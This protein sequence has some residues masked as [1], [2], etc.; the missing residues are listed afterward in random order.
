MAQGKRTR[1]GVTPLPEYQA[2]KPPK[3]PPAPVVTN[4]S[5]TGTV[6]ND[7]FL[8][9]TGNDTFSGGAGLDTVDYSRAGTRITLKSQGVIDK[10]AGGSDLIAG[11]ESIIG[12]VG[13]ANLIDGY[14]AGAQTT[15][16]IIDLA[17][18]ALTINGIPYL[19]SVSFGVTNFVDVRG[20]ANGDIITGST[21]DNRFFGSAGNDVYNGGAGFD[22]LD[23][24]TLGTAV[25]LTSQGFVDKGALGTD[26]ISNVEAILGATGLNNVIDG[27]VA[28][29]ATQTTSFDVDLATARLTVS[30]IP[31]LGSVTFRVE[32]FS[33]VI[34]TR[35]ADKVLGDGRDNRLE[36]A[37]GNDTLGGGA[38]QDVLVGG[39]GADRLEGGN[40]DDVLIGGAG[41]DVLVLGAGRDVVVLLAREAESDQILDFSAR[42]DDIQLSSAGFGLAVGALQSA[43]FVASRAGTATAARAQVVYDTDDGMLYFDADGSGLGASV[44]LAKFAGAPALSLADISIIA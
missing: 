14:V 37:A 31:G 17:A 21:L 27:T 26:V 41:A 8:G 20:T 11:V 36:G 22:T 40:G 3:L 19:G 15:S 38:G 29:P 33:S 24:T 7:V 43:N 35:N 6:G 16:F 10:A 42:D 39:S 5:I 30:G 34:G 25:T 1:S 12:A 28:V 32:S 4:D 44:L 13:V 9:G 23:Y 18:N 2:P